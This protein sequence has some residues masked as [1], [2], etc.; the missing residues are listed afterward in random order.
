M[1]N[2][3][4]ESWIP[5]DASVLSFTSASCANATSW[6]AKVLQLANDEFDY[7]IYETANFVQVGLQSWLNAN[8]SRALPTT[9]ETIAWL[10]DDDFTVTDSLITFATE[11][12]KR[13][14][15]EQMPWKGNPDLAGRGV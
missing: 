2:K 7:P 3:S 13:T 4:L 5:P 12:C 15:C 10:M 1:A 14:F 11:E 6:L 9:L 8:E